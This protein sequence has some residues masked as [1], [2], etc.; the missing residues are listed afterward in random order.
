MVIVIVA[1]VAVVDPA[2]TVVIVKS[3]VIVVLTDVAV[4]VKQEEFLAS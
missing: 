1:D 3:L 4:V 2:V